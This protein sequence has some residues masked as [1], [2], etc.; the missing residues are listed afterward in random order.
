MIVAEI[1]LHNT[2]QAAYLEMLNAEIY[3]PLRNTK[4]SGHVSIRTIYIPCVITRSRR[5]SWLYTS[6]Y[7]S[8]REASRAFSLY[9]TDLTMLR[10]LIQRYSMYCRMSQ[11]KSGVEAMFSELQLNFLR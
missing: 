4:E 1:T 6:S 9:V 8:F 2:Y 10:D 7:S 11:R 3:S 5:H